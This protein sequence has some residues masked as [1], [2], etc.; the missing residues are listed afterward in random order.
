MVQ[1]RRRCRLR[2]RHDC[3]TVVY[4]FCAGIAL[5][6]ASCVIMFAIYICSYFFSNLIGGPY[7]MFAGRECGVALAKMSFDDEWLDNLDEVNKLNFGERNELEGWIDKFTH[8]RNYPIKGRLIPD[9]K[10]PDPNRIVTKEE[11]AKNNGLQPVPEGYATAPI[12]I[13]ADN[14][15]FDMSFGGIQFYGSG[16]PYNKFAGKNVTLALAMMSLDDDLI[17]SSDVGGCNEKQI[18][19]MR[20]WIKTFE[21][22][23]GY[24]IVAK[25]KKC[26]IN[27]TS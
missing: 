14:K 1:V 9:N 18:Q 5:V 10:L 22:R 20:D 12:Y 24:P 13:A 8:Y 3:W 7:E 19:T 27:S 16:G 17:G 2:L 4:G 23:K 11:L 26:R 15:I 21:E 25:F 6:N